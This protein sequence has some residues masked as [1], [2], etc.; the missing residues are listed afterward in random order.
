L[1]PVVVKCI[2]DC[3]YV[4]DIAAVVSIN[5]TPISYGCT[6]LLNNEELQ[7]KSSKA[8]SGGMVIHDIFKVRKN[9][10]IRAKY[11]GQQLSPKVRTAFILDIIRIFDKF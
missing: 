6:K 9:G 8:I 3:R 7:S 10:K 4:G 2:N 5:I 1:H 11:Y